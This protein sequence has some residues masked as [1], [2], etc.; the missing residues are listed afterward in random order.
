MHLIF[1]ARGFGRLRGGGKGFSE[2]AA[3]TPS[4]AMDLQ[5]KGRDEREFRRE[6]WSDRPLVVAAL[7]AKPLTMIVALCPPKP[8]E[9]LTATLIFCSRATFGT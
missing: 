5:K 8:K 9:L 6:G 4:V 1:Q 7:Y 2:E 3:R